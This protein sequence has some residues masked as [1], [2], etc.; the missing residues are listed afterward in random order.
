MLQVRLQRIPGVTP[1][2]VLR[3]SIIFGVILNDFEW[4]E[5]ADW[6][7]FTTVSAGQ[8]TQPAGGKGTRGRNLRS[9]SLEV[10]TQWGRKLPFEN[11]RGSTGN[12]IRN[13]LAAITRAR[14]PFRFVATM[15]RAFDSDPAELRM[16][17][18]LRSVSRLTRF[19]EPDSR[20]LTIE[21]VEY[22]SAATERRS[23]T[24]SDKFPIKHK[25]DA[26][27]T[28][29]KLAKRYWKNKGADWNLIKKANGGAGGRLKGVG[30][31]EKIV[32]AGRY[33]VGDTI[34]IPETRTVGEVIGGEATLYGPPK[35]LA[36]GP[37]H[38]DF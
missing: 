29:R 6:R 28:L 37:V 2:D 33:K 34:V 19:G 13:E 10:L 30:P 8:R 11:A 5:A 20:Y 18:T 3:K 36:S 1:R 17:A 23:R 24:K 15:N 26:D 4:S 35:G 31:D 16:D 21:I 25:L 9:L 22:R 38:V 14:A 12:E 7:D 32:K 27:D